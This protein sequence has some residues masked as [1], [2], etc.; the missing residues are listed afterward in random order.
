M[1]MATSS[2]EMITVYSKFITLKNGK[3]VYA[4]EKGIEAFRFQV[5]ASKYRG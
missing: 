3:R 5:P 1:N 4:W 2:E